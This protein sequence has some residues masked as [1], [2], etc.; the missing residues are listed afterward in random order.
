[1]GQNPKLQE[2]NSYGRRT[3]DAVREFQKLHNLV[4]DGL[5]GTKT[6]AALQAALVAVT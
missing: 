1:L 4:S 6:I 5:V 2:D 3:R